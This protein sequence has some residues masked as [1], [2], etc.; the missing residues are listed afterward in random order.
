MSLNLQI[1]TNC[2]LIYE[3]FLTIYDLYSLMPGWWN[4]R[5]AHAGCSRSLHWSLRKNSG[6]SQ[7]DIYFIKTCVYCIMYT[8]VLCI[9]KVLRQS[10]IR[11][12][13]CIYFTS[14]L[15]LP[16]VLNFKVK[17]HF[18]GDYYNNEIADQ[19]DN[20]PVYAMIL[21]QSR[22]AFTQNDVIF[23][24]TILIMHTVI[25]YFSPRL[26]QH[27]TPTVKC[28]LLTLCV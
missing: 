17:H 13:R 4:L 21:P 14:S 24:T 18:I 9:D 28:L 22:P 19:N 26:D 7:L 10:T 11:Y 8:L 6:E 3:L 20:I 5:L 12:S 25:L 23:T 2:I 1:S 16:I 15:Y 27:L